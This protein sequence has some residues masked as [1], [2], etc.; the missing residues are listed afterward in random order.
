VSWKSH[1]KKEVGVLEKIIF[2]T[3]ERCHYILATSQNWRYD[4]QALLWN[5]MN[6]DFDIPNN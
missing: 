5:E 1:C 6:N 2:S 3:L 4:N